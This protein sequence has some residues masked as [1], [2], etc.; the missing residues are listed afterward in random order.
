MLGKTIRIR[1]ELTGDEDVVLDGQVEGK[2]ELTKSLTIG[3]NANVQADVQ[4]ANIAVSG[5]FQGNLMSSGRVEIESSATVIGNVTA[6]RI[7]IADGAYYQGT[8]EMT[9][10][11]GDENR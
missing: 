7:S 11:G 5:K 1:G 9:G 2:I 8:V 4:A 6:P 10:R 3:R